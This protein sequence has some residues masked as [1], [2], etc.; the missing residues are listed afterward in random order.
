MV[1]EKSVEITFVP[2]TNHKNTLRDPLGICK[3][4][5]L[6]KSDKKYT[7]GQEPHREQLCNPISVSNTRTAP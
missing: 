2:L 1:E 5:E 6:T 7:E 4:I 3:G